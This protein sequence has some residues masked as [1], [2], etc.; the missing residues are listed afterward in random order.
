MAVIRF[1]F[2]LALTALVLA[3]AHPSAQVADPVTTT[4]APSTDPAVV[5]DSF[6]YPIGKNE[7]VTQGKDKDERYNALVFGSND[8]LGEDWN[9]NTGGNTDC[10]EPVYAAANGVVT[11]AE[12]AGPGWGNVVIIE[13]TLTDGKRVQSLYG[14]LAK[15]LKTSGDVEIREKI[16]E[17]GNADGRYLGHLHHE[18]R[19]EDCRMWHQAGGG[20]EAQGRQGHGLRGST[21]R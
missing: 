8:H 20:K 21:S 11:F 9:K 4:K 12:D 2:I 10:G 3:C 6:A 13:H 7:T 17:V 5:A 16:G 1:S 18:I 19:T 15:I 14:H